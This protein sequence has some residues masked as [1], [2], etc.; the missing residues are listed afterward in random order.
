MDIKVGSKLVIMQDNY[1][2]I[3]N[4]IYT[5]TD[6]NPCYVKDSVL[7][8]LDGCH[9]EWYYPDPC[10]F[11]PLSTPQYKVTKKWR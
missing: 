9:R 6:I 11:M 10:L 4:E 7:I 3:K 5:V 2:L 8:T 1:P